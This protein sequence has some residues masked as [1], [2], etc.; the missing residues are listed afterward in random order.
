M[1]VGEVVTMS[2]KTLNKVDLHETLSAFSLSDTTDLFNTGRKTVVEPAEIGG[3]KVNYY[4]NEYW[5]SRQRQANNLHEIA[6]RACFKP[7]LPGFFISLLSQENDTIFDPFAGR[8]TTVIEAALMNR[9]V[10]SNDINPLSRTLTRPRLFLPDIEFL[11]ERLVTIAFDY[12]A[13]ADLDLT[14]FY[15]PKTESEIVSLKHYLKNRQEYGK[16]D[17]L[18]SWIRM[19]ATN[20]LTG[21]SPGYFS[22]YTLPPNQAVSP[23]NQ[24]KINEKRKQKPDYRN[25]RDLII[26]K[27][28]SLIKD[29]RNGTR[30]TL[31]NIGGTAEF[32]SEDARNICGIENDTVQLTVTSPPFLDVVQYADDN[33]LRC[34]FNSIDSNTMGAKISVKKSIDEW[35]SIMMDVFAELYRI[36]RPGG[37]VAFEVGE[38]RGGKV[39]LEERIVPCGIKANFRCLGIMI[40]E[41]EFTKTANIWG[42]KNNLKGTNTNRI[43]LFVKSEA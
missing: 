17:E 30:A 22:V 35:A 41:Q 39:N 16:E 43:V 4:I 36:T 21:H 13:K 33:W 9:R 3:V 29:I 32:F 12:T 10:I 37:Y 11:E 6:Y 15:H 38:V 19:V 31:R 28:L 40:N 34:W 7:Q 5:T 14:M 26:K 18:D 2:V 25:T 20:R 24:V 1:E 8:G 23:S 27:T 42:V